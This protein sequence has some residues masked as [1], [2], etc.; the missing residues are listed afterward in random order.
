MNYR[1]KWIKTKS[2]VLKRDKFNCRLCGSHES[3]C[4]HHKDGSGDQAYNEKANNN[5][6]NLLTV[7]RK[8]H[9]KLHWIEV[10]KSGHKNFYEYQQ[11]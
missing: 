8:C 9:V 2:T 7:C 3:L 5:F 6:T 10:K 1:D 11:K 4:I